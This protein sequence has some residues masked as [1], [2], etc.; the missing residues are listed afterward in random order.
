VRNYGTESNGEKKA[1]N[2]AYPVNMPPECACGVAINYIQ[3][4]TVAAVDMGEPISSVR[5]RSPSKFVGFVM[6]ARSA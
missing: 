2:N 4:D 5:P 6:D 1:L 3:A